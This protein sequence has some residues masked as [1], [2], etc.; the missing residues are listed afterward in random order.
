MSECNCV[1]LRR[2]LTD[3]L[4]RLK[5]LEDVTDITPKRER[6]AYIKARVAWLKDHD[7]MTGRQASRIA[8]NE[9]HFNRMVR[10]PG[11]NDG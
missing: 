1:E 11:V 8:N 7:G 2:Q 4:D 3:V 10:I 9:V 5:E 6:K